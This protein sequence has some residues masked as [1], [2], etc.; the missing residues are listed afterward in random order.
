M[1]DDLLLMRT[2][3]DDRRK[4]QCSARGS[5]YWSR[6]EVLSN[7]IFIIQ[8]TAPKEPSVGATNRRFITPDFSEALGICCD[9]SG[10]NIQLMI[11]VDPPGKRQVFG[12]IHAVLG[13]TP[14]G[15]LMIQL[16]S[17]DHHVLSRVGKKASVDLRTRLFPIG[18]DVPYVP[19][20]K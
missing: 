18:N 11:Y 3:I 17:G 6:V 1:R 7:A 15:P 10:H 19:V 12:R 2:D 8:T 14:G 4:P 5:R 13:E 20:K 9:F 16:D